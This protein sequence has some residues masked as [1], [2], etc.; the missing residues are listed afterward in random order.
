L[1]FFGEGL[2]GGEVVLVEGS[3]WGCWER[4][5]VMVMVMMLGAREGGMYVR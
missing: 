3:W 4:R 2:E 5:V 1:L